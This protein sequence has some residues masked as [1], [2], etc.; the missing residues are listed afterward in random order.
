[1]YTS[2][3]DQRLCFVVQFFSHWFVLYAT[4]CVFIIFW[5]NGH[6]LNYNGYIINYDGYIL[7]YHKLRWIHRIIQCIHRIIQCIHRIIQCI[8][9]IWYDVS[10]VLYNVSIVFNTNSLYKVYIALNS[11]TLLCFVTQIW[12]NAYGNQVIGNLI[13]DF[14]FDCIYVRQ[15]DFL[16]ST[17]GQTA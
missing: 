1:M 8:H 3:K 2:Y 16:Q 6:I 4:K 11:N 5:Y 17:Q 7:Y 14:F 12:L 10:I 15:S 9:Y 13:T